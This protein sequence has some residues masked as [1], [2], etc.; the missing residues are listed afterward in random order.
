MYL[1]LDFYKINYITVIEYYMGGKK[2]DFLQIAEDANQEEDEK[3]ENEVTTNEEPVVE[4]KPEVEVENKEEKNNIEKKEIYYIFEKKK[5]SGSFVLKSKSFNK[6]KLAIIVKEKDYKN[7][8]I[9]SVLNQY[10][11]F[12]ATSKSFILDNIDNKDIFLIKFKV[13]VGSFSFDKDGK[14]KL[15]TECGKGLVI[16]TKEYEANGNYILRNR[17]DIIAKGEDIVML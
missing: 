12:I 5:N 2:K 9:N 13:G 4:N 11:N 1:A 17:S 6:N 7:A 14:K 3:I 16:K 15:N 10:C 8:Y